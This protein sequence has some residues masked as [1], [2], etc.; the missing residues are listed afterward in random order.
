[1]E[2]CG[3]GWD[4]RGQEDGARCL[5]L[6]AGVEG[7]ERLTAMTTNVFRMRESVAPV[8]AGAREAAMHPV[9]AAEELP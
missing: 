5:S 3:V 6:C 4:D 9:S 8:R 2:G 7:W 1:M